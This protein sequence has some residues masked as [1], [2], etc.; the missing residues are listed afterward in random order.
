M[1]VIIVILGIIAFL[2]MEHPIALWLVFVPL[3][4]LLIITIVAWLKNSRARL[5][6]LITSM[7]ILALMVVALLFVCGI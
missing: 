4:V 1:W 6:G 7:F 5:S 2:A 3:A